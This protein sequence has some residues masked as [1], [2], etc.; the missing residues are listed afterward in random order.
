MKC[1]GENNLKRNCLNFIEENI[2]LLF[3]RKDLNAHQKDILKYNMETIV[4]CCGLNKNYY[5]ISYFSELSKE[6]ELNRMKSE[7]ILRK[8]KTRFNSKNKDYYD[9]TNV[10]IIFQRIRKKEI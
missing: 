6:K 7:T 10:N 8:F 5:K 1:K 4:Q 9:K 3:K 2:L